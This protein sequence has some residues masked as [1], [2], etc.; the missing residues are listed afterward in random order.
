MVS[1]SN[2]ILVEFDGPDGAHVGRVMLNDSSPPASHADVDRLVRKAFE[3]R[4]HIKVTN[5]RRVDDESEFEKA[6][7]A[8][9]TK[10]PNRV[11]LDEATG[12]QPTRA[13]VDPKAFDVK[14]EN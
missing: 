8:I 1:T 6:K 12:G 11:T 13:I 10:Y 9:L 14:D 3:Q 5:W 4:D 7:A 2:L